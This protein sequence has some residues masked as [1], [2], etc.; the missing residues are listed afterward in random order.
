MTLA[1]KLNYLRLLVSRK[2]T[3]PSDGGYFRD[4]DNLFKLR[5]RSIALRRPHPPQFFCPEPRT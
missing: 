2:I 3:M 4:S 1:L 5:L